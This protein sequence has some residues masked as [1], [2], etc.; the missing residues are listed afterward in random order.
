MQTNIILGKELILNKLVCR[1]I[2]VIAFTLL[3]AMG[4]YLRVPLW[5]TPVPL[6][7]QTFFVILSGA[8]L[9]PSLGLTSQVIY[10]VLGLLGVPLFA[11]TG[12]TTAYL[13]GPTTGYLFGFV[14][15]SFLS[16]KLF[17]V[18]RTFLRS[19]ALFFSCSLI[20]LLSGAV[21]LGI[22][23][24]LGIVKAFILG[25]LP[26]IAGDCLK[27]YAAALIYSRIAKRAKEIF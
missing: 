12:S 4:A 7:L 5:F 22:F 21:W 23:L 9:G 24:K 25:V 16:G 18:N 8:V 19:F 17:A 2:G 10:I 1:V 27:A 11:N 20:I 15:C 3:S 26:F 14:I 6:T 13:M